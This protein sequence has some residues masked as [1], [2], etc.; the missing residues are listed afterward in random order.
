MYSAKEISEKLIN[1]GF[2]DM[3]VRKINYYAFEKK[4]FPVNGNGKSVFS[5]TDYDKFKS[6]AFLRENSKYSLEEIKEKIQ[7]NTFQ[8]IN[9][10][11]LTKAIGEYTSRN[12]FTGNSVCANSLFVDTDKN[13]TDYETSYTTSATS[14]NSDSLSQG[15]SFSNSCCSDNLGTSKSIN[16]ASN[17]TYLGDSYTGTPPDFFRSTTPMYPYTNNNP[18]PSIATQISSNEP[19]FEEKKTNNKTRIKISKGIFIEYDET[20]NQKEIDKLINMAKILFE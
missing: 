14:I 3:T 20:A 13:N 15:I 8:E 11:F 12:T 19:C 17:T 18:L 4:M 7:N 5:E 2:T 1:D 16:T 9:N 10:M 6:I